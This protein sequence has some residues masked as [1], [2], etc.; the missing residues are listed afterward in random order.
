MSDRQRG[1]ILFVGLGV[2]GFLAAGN[3]PAQQSLSPR[4]GDSNLGVAFTPMGSVGRSD[5]ATYVMT[6]LSPDAP[7]ALAEVSLSARLFVD[8]PGSYGGRVYVD[9]LPASRVLE[10]RLLVDSVAAGGRNF[11]REYW[12]V[13]AGM[14]M[15]DGVINCYTLSGGRYCIVSLVQ[16]FRLGKPGEQAGGMPLD[17]GEMRTRLLSSLRDSTAALVSRFN[18]LLSSVQITGR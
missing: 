11:R 1:A 8:L 2:A 6:H 10:S 12:T 18:G 9:S 3:A 5:S 15:W 13:Y 4:V 7:G 16:Q 17:A 14:G